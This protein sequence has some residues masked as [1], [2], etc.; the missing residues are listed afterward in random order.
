M[1]AWRQGN[2]RRWVEISADSVVYIDPGLDAP[3]VGKPAYVRYL[4]P[5]Q[6]KIFYDGSEYVHPRAAAYGNTAVLTYNYHSLRKR[7]DGRQERTSFWNT[8]EVYRRTG[9]EWRIVHTHWSYIQH[10]LPESL[11]VAALDVARGTDPLEGDA[12]AI[13]ELETAAFERWRQGD[14]QG[15]LG[16]YA[17]EI[18]TF[19]ADTPTRLNGIEELKCEYSARARK[20]RYDRLEFGSPRL[21]FFGDAAVL[22]Y[23]FVAT[24]LHPDGT[25]ESRTPWNSTKVYVKA[26]GNWKIVHAHWSYVKGQREDGGI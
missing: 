18:T 1:E 8:T 15:F 23:Q 11:T 2:P 24:T 6:G 10:H 12:A 16:L 22:F 25:V 13:W 5:L 19:D 7:A 21:Q 9:D 26:G 20:I 3:V 17:P 4:E 14:P